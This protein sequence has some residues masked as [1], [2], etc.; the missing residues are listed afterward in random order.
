MSK[1][2]VI[3]LREVAVEAGLE[4]VRAASIATRMRDALS[5][6]RADHDRAGIAFKAATDAAARAETELYDKEAEA[7]A[8]EHDKADETTRGLVALSDELASADAAAPSS[9]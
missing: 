2:E 6:A 1:E 8:A 7:R 9:V 4:M 5:R 3:R